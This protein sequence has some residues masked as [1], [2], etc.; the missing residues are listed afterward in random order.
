M[1]QAAASDCFG[2]WG[3]GRVQPN[4]AAQGKAMQGKAPFK[5]GSATGFCNL[6]AVDGGQ[7][8]GVRAARVRVR[9]RGRDDGTGVP[10][11]WDRI[12]RTRPS[13]QSCNELFA[14]QRSRNAQD[15]TAGKHSSEKHPDSS[16]PPGRMENSRRLC[17]TVKLA[18]SRQTQSAKKSCS[19][20][21]SGRDCVLA[22]L[23]PGSWSSRRSSR[24]RKRPIMAGLPLARCARG[25]AS[26]TTH[27]LRRE[28]C[29]PGT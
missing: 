16:P 25:A 12:G 14:H 29:L 21:S 9:G 1:T 27:R 11:T 22:S 10:P 20:R 3:F 13:E 28:L 7:G 2:S 5:G 17:R 19:R 8:P 26:S 23:V 4:R 24:R 15:R 18:V 6:T